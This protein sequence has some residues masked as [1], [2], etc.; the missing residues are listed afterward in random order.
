VFVH[1]LFLHTTEQTVALGHQDHSTIDDAVKE[2]K[3]AKAHARKE[4][5]RRMEEVMNISILRNLQATPLIC[6]HRIN[7]PAWSHITTLRKALKC[8]LVDYKQEMRNRAPELTEAEQLEQAE[9]QRVLENAAKQLEQRHDDVKVMNAMMTYAKC[10]AVRDHQLKEK[11]CLAGDLARGAGSHITTQQC[12]RMRAFA[13]ILYI[14]GLES[15][16]L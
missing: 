2:S 11:V 12:C 9:R 5:M 10:V 1:D 7:A 16:M 4:M 6:S 13:F 3:A 14:P 15:N 8:T